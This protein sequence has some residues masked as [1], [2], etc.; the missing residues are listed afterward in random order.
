MSTTRNERRLV[1]KHLSKQN[2]AIWDDT[3]NLSASTLQN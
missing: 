3:A 1:K 2:I